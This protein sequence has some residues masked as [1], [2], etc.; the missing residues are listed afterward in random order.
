ME[1]GLI[2]IWNLE[3][4]SMQNFPL[5]S[6]TYPDIVWKL[7]SG[8]SHK[9]EQEK[10]LNTEEGSDFNVFEERKDRSEIRRTP[11]SKESWSISLDF[12]IIPLSLNLYF[13]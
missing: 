5:G 13:L 11:S 9:L 2:D 7:L 10:T 12:Q 6:K 1:W 8:T 4:E 3:V